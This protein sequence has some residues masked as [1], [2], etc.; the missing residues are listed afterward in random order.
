MPYFL[1]GVLM[2][3]VAGIILVVAYTSGVQVESVRIYKD[4]E[5][6]Q[7]TR[8]KEASIRCEIAR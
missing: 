7:V 1:A 3:L 4:C 2:S 6:H 8:I 5:S